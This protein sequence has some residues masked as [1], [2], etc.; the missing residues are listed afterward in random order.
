MRNTGGAPFYLDWPVAVGLLDPATRQ[1]L[2]SAALEGVDIRTWMPGEDWDS[3][4][5]AYRRPAASH[6]AMGH[7]SVPGEL[8]RGQYILALAIL[9][10]QGG[11]M[12]SV[13]FATDNYLRGGWH[14]LG[15]IGVGAAPG[16]AALRDIAFDR[17]AFDD[18][19]RY[20][21]PRELRAVAMPAL[22]EIKTVAP[23]TADTRTE[24]INPGR[25]WILTAP[26]G[27]PEKIILTDAANGGR[28]IRVTGDYRSGASLN[29]D[30]GKDVRLDRGHYR[31]AFRVRGTSGQT[32][33]FELADG[34]RRISKEGE[35]MLAD[36]WTEHTID[37]EIKA[38]FQEETT[39]RFNLPRAVAGTFD[40][41]EPR[42][43]KT[44]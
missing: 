38:T 35:L 6:D 15:R 42:L 10:R 40:L 34:W 44:E 25:Y 36:E 1:P 5:F 31:F 12:P 13:R 18:S 23:W 39:L 33:A 28:I 11:M 37:F 17:P 2:W 8:R 43:R 16:D 26:D 29:Y 24:L 4:A 27:G 21:V 9:D 20:A 41:A 19:L 14:P 3:E 7:A 22:P 30:F 32:V